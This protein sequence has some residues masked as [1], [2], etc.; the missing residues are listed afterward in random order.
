MSSAVNN[1][2]KFDQL[3]CTAGGCVPN[4][5]QLPVPGG[6]VIASALPVSF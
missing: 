2:G 4:G 3:L 1:A 5:G 6:F